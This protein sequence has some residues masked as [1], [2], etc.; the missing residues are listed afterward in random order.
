MMCAVIEECAE[1]PKRDIEKPVGGD[2]RVASADCF[3]NMHAPLIVILLHLG[4]R[5]IFLFSDGL[6][7]LSF[8]G[9]QNEL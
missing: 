5:A 9:I 6:R 8:Y 4:C 2:E 3:V 1:S 7:Y